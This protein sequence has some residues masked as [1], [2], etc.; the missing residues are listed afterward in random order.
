MRTRAGRAR[1]SLIPPLGDTAVF[2]LSNDAG[3]RAD[4]QAGRKNFIWWTSNAF[5]Y[6]VSCFRDQTVAAYAE[7]QNRA[8]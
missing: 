7:L 8:D 4:R 1:R 6:F 5:N 2:I 3:C